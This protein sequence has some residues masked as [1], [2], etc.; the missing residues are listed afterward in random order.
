MRARNVLL[1]TGMDGAE[2][3]AAAVA[4]QVHVH[5]EVAG[6]RRA[7]LLAL[8]RGEFSVVVVEQS[9]VEGDAE[10]ADQIW[11]S[12]GQAL[13]LEVN[14]GISGAARLAREIRGAL[15]R[16]EGEQVSARRAAA[17]DIANELK[18]SIT[19]LLLQ[20]ELMLREPAVT[21]AMEPKLRNLVAL[22]RTLR[23]R[24]LAASAH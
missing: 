8:R 15:A 3:C 9:L 11:T 10:W 6:S 2:S 21:K 22:A 1:I 24:L 4:E 7:G 20:S 19:G 5:V 12:A 23:E 14:F 18:S 16:L 17:E 13:P